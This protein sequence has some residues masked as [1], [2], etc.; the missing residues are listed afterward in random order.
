MRTDLIKASEL[1]FK[2]HIEKHRINVENLLENGVGVAEHPDIMETI[3]KELEIMAEYD[4]KLS[5]LN[6]YF[7]INDGSKGV[8]NG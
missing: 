8:L 4:D 2:A 5:I 7:T 6:K 1:H 3:E